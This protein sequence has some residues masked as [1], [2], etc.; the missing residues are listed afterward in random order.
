MK[1]FNLPT[2]ILK[3]NPD[4]LKEAQNSKISFIEIDE[5]LENDLN[6]Y[7]VR[8]VEGYAQGIMEAGILEP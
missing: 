4:I 5:I 7:T 2:S 6:L 1:S 8:N 3:G